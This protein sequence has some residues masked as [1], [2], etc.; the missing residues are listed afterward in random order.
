MKNKLMILILALGVMSQATFAASMALVPVSVVQNLT[1]PKTTTQY[2]KLQ[3]ICKRTKAMVGT[4]NLTPIALP[5]V[6]ASSNRLQI[7]QT[8]YP[9][10]PSSILR[11]SVVE[12]IA[13]NSKV[14]KNINV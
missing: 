11:A 1:L 10:H 3:G 12:K 14:L 9:N 5:A 13:P 7:L 2:S 4:N 6:P 8:K